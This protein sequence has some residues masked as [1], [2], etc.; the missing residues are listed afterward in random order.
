[1]MCVLLLRGPQTPGE[2][3]GR[4]ERFFEFDDL[5]AVE[6]TLQQLIEREWVKKLPRQAGSRESRFAHL[7]SGDV[8]PGFADAVEAATAPGEGAPSIHS[9][10]SA[11]ETQLAE[12]RREF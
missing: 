8:E 1:I 11:L 3:R 12:L 5:E 10:V 7:F 2:L 4:T 6:R 9:R